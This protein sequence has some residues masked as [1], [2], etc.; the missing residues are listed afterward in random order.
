[1][2]LCLKSAPDS[3]FCKMFHSGCWAVFW[4]CLGF[5]IYQGSEYVTSSKCARVLNI[6]FAKYKKK[7]LRFFSNFTESYVSSKLE[8]FF[9]RTKRYFFRAG[10][11][12]KKYKK[13][14]GRDFEGWGQKVSQVA[15]YFTTKKF[16]Y[17]LT[18]Y[19]F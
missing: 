18:T 6:P 15:A 10:I 1:M 5:W 9:L 14:F 17:F 3:Y 11:F 7:I 19:I 8:K 4:I 16:L 12:K 2:S 13:F